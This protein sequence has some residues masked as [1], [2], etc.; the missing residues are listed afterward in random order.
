MVGQDATMLAATSCPPEAVSELG[1]GGRQKGRARDTKVLVA[2]RHRRLDPSAAAATNGTK[3]R[4]GGQHPCLEW[5]VGQDATMLPAT[6][7]PPGAS[8]EP[9]VTARF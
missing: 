7:C 1:A 3:L 6:S 5:M 4:C 9:A 2:L 8:S